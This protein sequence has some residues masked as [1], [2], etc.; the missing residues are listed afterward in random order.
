MSCVSRIPSHDDLAV[1]PELAILAVLRVSIE[2]ATD[3]LRVVHPVDE[4]DLH[5]RDAD[6]HSAATVVHLAEALRLA[7]IDY[8]QLMAGLHQPL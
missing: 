6:V 8:E 2:L 7:I 5:G 1:S 3:A 4:R